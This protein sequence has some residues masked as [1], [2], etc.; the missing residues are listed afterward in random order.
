MGSGHTSYAP[1]TCDL[2][3]DGDLYGI[4]VRIS[5]YL[6]FAATL[7]AIFRRSVS[8]TL[9]IGPLGRCAEAVNILTFAILIVLVKNTLNGSFAT[10]E[11]FLTYPTIL[12][13]FFSLF[14][15]LPRSNNK[16]RLLCYAFTLSLL[17]VCQPWLY[18]RRMYQGRKSECV[19]RY[20]FFG[21]RDFYGQTWITF[22]KV[23]SILACAIGALSLVAVLFFALCRSAWREWLD[24][25]R[26]MKAEYL[27]RD[28]SYGPEEK[29]RRYKGL[30]LCGLLFLLFVGGFTM[31]MTEKTISVNNIDLADTPLEST[32]QLIPFVTG[33]LSFLTTLYSCI[34]FKMIQD[35]IAELDQKLID[36][37]L[38]KRK[39]VLPF[40]KGSSATSLNPNPYMYYNEPGQYQCR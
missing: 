36:K 31:V 38:G 6:F 3:G 19:V 4:G 8:H 26:K 11:W 29:K 33:L 16:G 5:Y 34:P 13:T 30:R 15:A 37:C 2:V 24:P 25:K 23:M 14:F 21:V 20:W 10:L 7:I 40:S 27:D 12:V 22:F 1:N 28:I 17:T 35:K 18:W 9:T 39:N 32:S